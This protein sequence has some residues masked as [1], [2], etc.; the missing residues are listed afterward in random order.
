V[1][2]EISRM[3]EHHR[4]SVGDPVEFSLPA[5]SVDGRTE[6]VQVPVSDAEYFL[7]ENR[8]RGRDNVTLTIWRDGSYHEYSAGNETDG[9]S[10]FDIS[11]FPGGVVVDVSNYDWALPGGIDEDGNVLSGGALIWHIDERVIR[12]GLST[13]R[14]NA[15]PRRRG[16]GLREADGSQDIG[17]PPL[18]DFGPQVHLGTPFDF[19]FEGNPVRVVTR[20]GREIALYENRF[21]PDT[22]PSSR[23]ND[24]GNS[25]IQIRD[26]SPS[27]ETI[28]FVV[29]R[30]DG[31]LLRR[32]AELEAGPSAI[33]SSLLSTRMGGDLLYFSRSAEN[34]P[35]ILYAIDP[36]TGERLQLFDRVASR[37]AFTPRGELVVVRD[38]SSG[39]E[40]VVGSETFPISGPTSS[41]APVALEIGVFVADGRGRLWRLGASQDA[42]TCVI[43]D[44]ATEVALASTGATVRFAS[45]GTLYS[46]SPSGEVT[47]ERALPTGFRA[48]TMVMA[49]AR[50]EV[51]YDSD[52][53]R[54]LIMNEAEVLGD[55]DA[56]PFVG[57]GGEAFVVPFQT[58][59]DGPSAILIASGETLA[60]FGRSGAM[61]DGFPIR[62]SAAVT[63]QP[64]TVRDDDGELMLVPMS[65]GQ[66]DGFRIASGGPERVSGFPL[67][68]GHSI[69]ATPAVIDGSLHV[70]SEAGRM[71]RYRFLTEVSSAYSEENGDPQNS[72]SRLNL[73]T[74]MPGVPP[75]F[76]IIESETYNWP[77]P[78]R[79]GHTYLRVATSHRADVDVHIADASGS[80]IERLTFRTTSPGVP[81]EVRW[82][83]DAASGLY[84]ARVRATSED[85]SEDFRVIKMAIL[86]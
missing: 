3:G 77:N 24:G 17:F 73:I 11:S 43:C 69:R 9:F 80:T 70:V 27:A 32:E 81:T 31:Q 23:T 48:T 76:S 26:F 40:M 50:D 28:T 66:L 45:G 52:S 5:A 63:A 19:Y 46:I 85:G 1:D 60:A 74:D 38:G 59:P 64:I 62:L 51:L 16:V 79:S 34:E 29:E 55:I 56:S 54:L 42:P 72:R 14:V 39:A 75:S 61:L 36:D 65:N 41:R 37:P 68:V 6:V 78:I 71:A 33:G 67:S 25:F 21:G 2:K 57:A 18:S 7:V 47:D 13:N 53:H 22:V 84:F 82:E 4:T 8:F 35:G 20:T 83:T 58:S 10:R 86:R 15:D 44:D 49:G 30:A 12:A